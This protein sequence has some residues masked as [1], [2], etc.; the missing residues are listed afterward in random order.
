MSAK[1][2]DPTLVGLHVF[3]RSGNGLPPFRCVGVMQKIGPIRMPDGT[4]IG[5]PGQPMGCCDHCGTGIADCYMIVSGDGKRFLVGSSCV[6]RAGDAGLLRAY[7]NN[8][9][10]RALHAAKRKGLDDRKT[11]ELDTLIQTNAAKL[12]GLP[13]KRY[14]GS[15]ESQFDYLTRVIPMCGA[16][17][18]ARYL[19]FV[20]TLIN[21]A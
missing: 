19:K 12:A 1:T 13:V 21:Q 6:E 18:R 11:A 5:S 17:G 15:M 3:T 4:E 16:S 10:V 2:D 14:D 9:Q 20:K 8:P 7:K